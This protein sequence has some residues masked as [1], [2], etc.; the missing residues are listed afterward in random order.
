[1]N[2]LQLRMQQVIQILDKQD[3][4]LKGVMQR[5]FNQDNLDVKWLENTLTTAEGIDRLESFAAKFARMQDRF[6]DKLL[7]LFLRH[8]GEIPK[9]AIDNL[10]R[11]EQTEHH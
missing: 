5:L 4:L 6:V 2:H 9:T 10:N 8:T 3:A 1:M 11:L 7:P